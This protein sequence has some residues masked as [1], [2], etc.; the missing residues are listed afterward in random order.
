[1]R[2]LALDTRSCCARSRAQPSSTCTCTPASQLAASPGKHA[3]PYFPTEPKSHRADFDVNR[4]IMPPKPQL[5]IAHEVAPTP[6]EELIASPEVY[7]IELAWLAFNWRVLSMALLPKVP[8]LER[9]Q[10]R[11]PSRI[12]LITVFIQDEGLA[13]TLFELSF[14]LALTRLH[15]CHLD[16]LSPVFARAQM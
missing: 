1:M 6:L 14:V 11:V 2:T 12:H 3:Q 4:L 10:V 8:L 15:V 7:N 16:G 9:L 5:G 13:V